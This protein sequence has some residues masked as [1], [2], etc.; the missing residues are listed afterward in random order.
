[1]T[2]LQITRCSDLPCHFEFVTQYRIVPTFDIDCAVAAAAPQFI[3]YHTP[4]GCGKA[5]K[6]LFA[7]RFW[8]VNT[9]TANNAPID[10]RIL[11]VN[12]KDFADPRMKLW[13]RVNQRQNLVTW[14]PF[15]SQILGWQ[16]IKYP[17]PRPWTMRN[18]P[19]ACVPRPVHMTVLERQPHA[20]GRRPFRKWAKYCA[21]ARK[22]VSDW[23]AWYSARKPA[24]DVTIK[25]RN[26]ID[27]L[28]PRLPR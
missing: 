26:M 25:H 28:R 23:L 19:I 17:F 13:K 27:Q 9:M 11:A 7:V 5:E 24:H 8:P 6:T 3:K 22:R 4:I 15:Q 1:M 14:L 21:K 10:G 2:L 16:R 18:V 20:K 12:V